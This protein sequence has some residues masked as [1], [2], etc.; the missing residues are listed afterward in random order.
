MVKNLYSVDE[1]FENDPE[2]SKNVFMK[3]PEQISEKLG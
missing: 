3:I 2:N 1:I